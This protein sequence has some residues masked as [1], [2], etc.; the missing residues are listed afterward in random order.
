[1]DS[2]ITWNS[3]K[4]KTALLNSENRIFVRSFVEELQNFIKILKV[5]FNSTSQKYLEYLT[6]SHITQ[7]LVYG[8]FYNLVLLE[9]KDYSIEQW[10]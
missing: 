7:C 6:D 2:L 10:K 9:S 3:W 4:V 1:M 8:L 5:S